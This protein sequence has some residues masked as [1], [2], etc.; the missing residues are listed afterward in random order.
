[1]PLAFLFIG[2]LFLVAAVRGKQT[3]LFGLLK[4]DFTGPKNFFYW[5]IAIWLIA[6]LGNIKE[7]RPLSNMFLVLVVLVLLLVN[8]G[9]FAQFMLQIGQTTQVSPSTWEVMDGN[10]TLNT[11]GP[12]WDPTS[13]MALKF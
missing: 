11:S 5:I 9:F 13:P 6:A 4:K 2:I 3:Q 8:K 1:M 12:N 7:L 10:M